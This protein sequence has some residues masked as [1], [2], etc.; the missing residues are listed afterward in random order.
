M[1]SIQLENLKE[2]AELKFG[3]DNSIDKQQGA[4][5]LCKKDII[6]F[7]KWWLWTYDPRAD[8]A[9]LPFVPYDY[10]EDFIRGI[11]SDIVNKSS[12]LTEKSRDMGATWMI[13][14]VFL[15]RWLF[16]NENFLLGS[17]KQETVDTIG[18]MDSHF[19]RLRYMIKRLPDWMLDL[20]GVNR[21]LSGFMKIYKDN[22]CSIT[23]ES[24]N[25]DFSRQGRYTAIM[26]DEL[27]FT[28]SPES[29]WRACGDSAPCKIAISTPNGS[30]NFFAHLRKQHHGN[31]KVYT[32][33]WRLHPKKD[34]AWYEAEKAKRSAKDI[35]QELDINYTISAGQPFYVGF[36]RGIHVRKMEPNNQRELILGWDYGFIHPNCVVTQLLPEGIWL[37]V[38]NIMGEN[39][40][41]DEFGE[42]VMAYLNE[43]YQGFQ[44]SE[45]C[46][47]DPAGKQASDKSRH[48]S[49]EIL[50][51]LGFRVKSIPSNSHLSGY[52]QRKQIIEKRLRTLIGGIPSLIVNDVPNNE[53]I[54][55]GFEGG[56]RYPDQNKYGGVIEKP[57][58]DGWFE[59]CMNSLEYVAINLF[60][61]LDIKESPKPIAM[62]QAIRDKIPFKSKQQKQMN[63]GISF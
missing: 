20:C 56:Y 7:F 50:N 37:I 42:C 52:A 36:S 34:E 55:E 47:G 14:G 8:I 54:I 40:T 4:Y 62:R 46:Y 2:R 12:S 61:K 53:I 32:L 1:D 39:Q 27:A 49:E 16:H 13:L 63:A 23:G 58:D 38:D 57:I 60:R 45:R 6:S 33:H 3:C 35:A 25:K 10:Q 9:E 43:Y 22:G 15:Y 31:I 24:M 44:F 41:I 29:I 28:D 5:N 21:I 11:E 17:R 51:Q 19:E 48:S 59:H 30:N 26:L 18:D